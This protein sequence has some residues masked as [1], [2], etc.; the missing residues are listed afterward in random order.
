[1]PYRHS[2]FAA[3]IVFGM[4]IPLLALLV[5]PSFLEAF[6]SIVPVGLGV[7]LA[8]IVLFYSLNVE[9]ADGALV[10][11][12]GIGLIRKRLLL[13]DIERVKVVRNP[14]YV[15]W[16]IRWMPG[17]Y[18]LW[19][20]SGVQAVELL[21]KDGTHFRIGT[22]EPEVL[23]RAIESQVGHLTPAVRPPNECHLSTQ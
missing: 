20:V 14:W 4:L 23:A 18:S 8:A 15:G 3:V 11:S 5:L 13:S 21:L 2:Q 12:F 7:L 1:M 22:D 9:I 10:C 16:G 17:Q 19:N 6:P